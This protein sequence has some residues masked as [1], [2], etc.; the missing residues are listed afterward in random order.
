MLRRR[1]V[2]RSLTEWAR[3]I[4][5]EPAPHHRLIIAEIEALLDS[6][7]YDTLLIF[8][9]PGSAK[10]SYVSIVT[11]SWYLARNARNNVLAASHSVTLAAKWGRRVRNLVAEHSKTLG[12]ELAGDSQAADRWATSEGGEYLAAGVGMGIAGFRADLGII[13]DPFGSREDA[14]SQKIRD[15][16]WDWFLND[17][18]ARLKPA[19]KRIVM[20]TRWHED[21]LAGRI[22]DAAKKGQ[23]RVRQLVLPA[24]AEENDPLGRKPGEYLW[25]EP[26][27]YNYGG[28]LRARERELSSLE[29]SA[30]Y[31]QRPVAEEG[32]IFKR[33]DWR[34][35]TANTWPD[36]RERAYV[37]ASLDPAYTEK[38]ENDPSGFT[39]W[40]V[41]NDRKTGDLQI[42]LMTAWQKRLPIHGPDMPR[43]ENESEAD[44]ITR[45]SPTWGLCEW[46]AYS[47]RKLKVDRLLIEAKASGISV[48]QEL[49]RL[50]ANEGW[51][52]QLVDP[53]GQDKVARAYSVQHLFAEGLIYAPREKDGVGFR[54]WAQ[55]VIDQAAKFPKDTHD[56]LVDSMTQALR[57]L[58]A[59]GLAVRR[60]ERIAAE[61]AEQMYRP[62]AQPLY[63]V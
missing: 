49:R 3:H 38:E 7:S 52:V 41:W 20:H 21:D 62:P 1:T 9:P 61:A 27:G 14:Y 15:K 45:V 50:H 55:M 4:G 6:A 46:V 29:W 51:G 42:V 30:L 24:R 23:Y 2:R 40:G 22:L 48:A 63:P 31:Q 13:D 33:A 18:S 10:S 37:V 34:V 16:I 28:F 53:K 59:L 8:A 44:Y 60:E 26:N 5:F 58:R 54:E 25:D 17:F 36:P 19:A 32:E 39:V 35:Y 47:C 56:D 12:V 57:H 11:P 43:R